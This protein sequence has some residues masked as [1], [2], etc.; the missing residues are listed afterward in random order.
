V[1]VAITRDD[2]LTQ[3]TEGIR[4]LTTS[5]AWI[6]WLHAQ[7]R[8]YQYSFGNT[9]LI[10]LQRPDATRV[11]GFH[12]WRRLGRQVRKGET[13]IRILAPCR[14]P[15]TDRVD[16]GDD[17]AERSKTVR[18]F[19]VAV[20]FAIEQT[21]G[22]PLPELPIARV[23][24]DDPAGCFDALCD[25]VREL[26]YAVTFDSFDSPAKCGETNFATH[27]VTLRRDLSPA[28]RVKTMFHELAHISLEHGSCFAGARN[29]AE[30]E[31]ESVA[32]ICCDAVEIAADAYSFAYVASWAGGG[33]AIAG[34]RDSGQRI[35]RVSKRIL[36]RLVP[37]TDGPPNGTVDQRHEDVTEGDGAATP[38]PAM[39]CAREGDE[40]LRAGESQATSRDRSSTPQICKAAV[41][42]DPARPPLQM[43]PRGG[44]RPKTRSPAARACSAPAAPAAGK[45][46]RAHQRRAAMPGVRV[47]THRYAFSVVREAEPAYPQDAAVSTP[48]DAVDIA[49]HVIGAEITECILAIFLTARHRVTGYAEVARGTI[50]AARFQP[51][52]VLV[53]ALLANA[54]VIVVAHCHPSG[55]VTPSRA[56]RVVTMALRQAAELIGLPLLDHIIVTDT[57][58]YSFRDAEGWD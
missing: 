20:V 34:I 58:H 7:S 27:V 13:G 24:G 32:W 50:N 36:E 4:Q 54:A 26:G 53:P 3:L 12:T 21:D 45:A 49:R 57:A 18:G 22:D 10:L 48:R 38:S 5:E 41:G 46:S 29:V 2:L 44:A 56:D 8:F 31:A 15:P 37:T 23:A 17:D 42:V 25:H 52:D 14:Y 40:L 11:A 47:T 51:R 30:L 6:A 33:D 43:P 28:H 35:Q 39:S 19:R 9:L 55:D 16:N 1:S